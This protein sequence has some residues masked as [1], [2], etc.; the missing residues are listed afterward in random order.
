[1]GLYRSA[2]V[3]FAALIVVGGLAACGSQGHAYHGLRRA[4]PLEVGA[5][6]LPDVTAGRAGSFA[7][8]AE[9]GT[10]LVVYFG[11]TSCPDQCPTTLADLRQAKEA[12]G[13]DGQKVHVAFAT[14]DPDRDTVTTMNQYLGIFF[15]P[16]QFDA[17]R[18]D[19]PNVL[20]PVLD[21]FLAKATVAPHAPGAAQYDVSHTGTAYVVDERGVVR[22]EWPFGVQG[23]D[24]AT[25]L[26][27]LLKAPAPAPA[28]AAKG[29]VDVTNAWIRPTPAGVSTGAAYVTLKAGHDDALV[30]VAVDPAVAKEAMVHGTT[31]SGGQMSM[32][33]ADRVALPAGTTVTMQPGGF[34]IMLMDLTS[35]LTAG[36][37]VALTLTFENA[38]AKVVEADVRDG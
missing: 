9:P 27:S 37:K 29:S 33:P 8:K 31:S 19:D 3:A 15:A 5:L 34:H 2:A 17:L 30:G 4:T 18:S 35:P 10:L 21:G 11:Y 22:L 24:M 16:G 12:M 20:T 7:F 6:S 23:T 25:D 1:M 32:Q 38:G 14:V 28:N 26:E 36:A 13:A